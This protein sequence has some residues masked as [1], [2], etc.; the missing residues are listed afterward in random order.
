MEFPLKHCLRPAINFY[1]EHSDLIKNVETTILTT[2]VLVG[3]IWKS[4]PQ[5]IPLVSLIVLRYTG[6]LFIGAQVQ[7]CQKSFYDLKLAIQYRDFP[8]IVLVASKVAVKVAT[9]FLTIAAFTTPLLG[10]FFSSAL[11]LSCATLL[12]PL[13][14]SSWLLGCINEMCDY[15]SNHSLKKELDALKIKNDSAVRIHNVVINFMAILNKDKIDI[16]AP[17]S[18]LA[19]KI[20]RQCTGSSL[21]L[22]RSS[23]FSTKYKKNCYLNEEEERHYFSELRKTLNQK[24]H[25]TEAGTALSSLGYL[26]MHVSK[27]YP[28]GP[29][30]WGLRWSMS[31]LYCMKT[32][33]K[34]IFQYLQRKRIAKACLSS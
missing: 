17:E 7:H 8:G 31:M 3:K 28:D 21:K 18:L 13:S 32:V 5:T 10:L 12:R 27:L 6:I 23:A 29:V 26:C 11:A 19:L 4:I 9:L 20:A 24:N 33:E 2:S 22:F 34:K 16:R 1:H 25:H 30:E 14:R 15:F